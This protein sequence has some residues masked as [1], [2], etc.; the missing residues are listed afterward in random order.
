MALTTS[1]IP[2]LDAKFHSKISVIHKTIKD[3]VS[4]GFAPRNKTG[5]QDLD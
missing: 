5:I 2:V 3:G 4:D 1:N